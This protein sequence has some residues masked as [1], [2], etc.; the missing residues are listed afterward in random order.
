MT[1][2]PKY[3]PYPEYKPSGVEWLGEVPKHWD[4]S[5]LGKYFEE[6]REKVSDKNYPPLSVTMK[7]IVPQLE[8]AAKTDAGDNRK[9]VSVGDFAINSRSDRKGSSGLS[10]LEGSVSLISIVLTPRKIE[11]SFVH[12]LLRS[13]PFQEEF[14]RYGKG[15]VADLWSTNYSEMKNIILPIPPLPEQRAIAAFLD[16][17]TGKI[18]RMIG[19]QERM[20]ELL[21]EK[22]QAVISNAVTKGLPAEASAKAGLDPNAPMK[23]SG[24]EWLGQI[25]EHWKRIPLKYGCS[26]LKDGTHLPPPRQAT[27]Y[28]LLSVRNMV[29]GRFVRLSDDSMI[30]EENY[31]E[32]CRSFIPQQNDVLL[33]IVG[34]TLGKVAIVPEM[35]AFH[36]QRSVAIFRTRQ[37]V[38]DHRFL[39]L[40]FIS[41]FFQRLLWQSVGFSAQPGIYLGVLQ[42]FPV[43]LPSIEEQEKIIQY[44]EKKTAKIDRLIAKAEQAIEL[45]KERR[46]ALISAAVT[47]KIDVS[48]CASTHADRRGGL[49]NAYCVT[50]DT[51][52]LMAA[53][54]QAEYKTKD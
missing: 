22:R 10:E 41:T 51:P 13:Q 21:K 36:I 25:P 20:I 14:Y 7:G 19:K 28:P 11:G 31:R 15:I 47:G 4:A 32:L 46:T 52:E 44:L 23:D 48:T 40:W 38:L 30:S 9:K 17:E 45:M 33:A 6:R 16:R 18:D 3:K 27:G 49:S 2:A 24:I 50:D 1:I 12:H 53:E 5:R 43:M 35:D 39:A 8:T 37:D 26:L 34:A 42:D 54:E 29:N